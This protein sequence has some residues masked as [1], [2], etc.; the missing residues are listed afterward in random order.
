[1]TWVIGKPTKYGYGLLVSDVAVTYQS[2]KVEESLQKVYP[3]GNFIAAGFSG[4]V[5]LGFR[6]LGY[7]TESLSSAGPSKMF[8]PKDVALKW[9][10]TPR[11]VFRESPSSLQSL[12]CEI[13]IVGI[14]PIEYL[15]VKQFPVVYAAALRSPS[16][17][18]E[19]S[20]DGALCIGRGSRIES[21]KNAIDGLD[22][23]RDPF[24]FE[25]ELRTQK[26]GIV[27]VDRIARA[28]KEY[29]QKGIS[30]ALNL[31]VV[32]QGNI[33]VTFTEAWEITDSESIVRHKSPVLFRSW[34][35]F[36]THCEKLGANASECSC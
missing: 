21:Y 3:V 24:A 17:E 20:R 8:S 19:L 29:P 14:S 4:S 36:R 31:C 34:E 25:F 30:E 7:L 16:F 35:K 23:K 2:G 9:Y 15:G 11:R 28:V 1:M 18:P 33:S 22:R 6:M 13:L 12:S 32:R 26:P 27:Y 10:R 5:E